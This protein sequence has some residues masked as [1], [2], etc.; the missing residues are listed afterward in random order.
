MLMDLPELVAEQR[1]LP[2]LSW[3]E[4]LALEGVSRHWRQLLAGSS[5]WRSIELSRELDAR[6]T[7]ALVARIAVRHGASVERLSLIDCV[8]PERTLIS[9]SKLFVIL[10]ELTVSG[11]R[12]LSDVGFVALVNGA[13]ANSLVSVRAAKCPELTDAALEALAKHHGDSLQHANF[14]HCRLLSSEGVAQFARSCRSLR[15]L[16]LRGCPAANSASLTVIATHCPALETLLVGG[17]GNVTD[18]ALVA[19]A[20]HCPSLKS[21]DISRSNPFGLGRGGGSDRAMMHLAHRC[22]HLE[23][24]NLGGQG[25]LTLA[26]V[27]ALKEH[28]PR[29]AKLEIG[30]CV[31]MTTSASDLVGVLRRMPALQSLNLSFARGEHVAL[32]AEQCDHIAVFRVDSARP[33]ARAA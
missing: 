26:T 17:A 4:L 19:V 30:G 14:S 16:A 13:A 20:D 18:D 9:A 2:L 33:M 5:R 7:S 15:S 29:L 8:V 24:I 11:C 28:C 1:L 25:R 27:E 12:Q 22:Q 6:R 32:I 10:S 31:G 21:L 3:T 23:H